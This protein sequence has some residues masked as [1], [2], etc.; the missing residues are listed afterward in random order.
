MPFIKTLKAYGKSA[1]IMVEAKAKD[2]A[3]LK[4]VEEL[5]KVRGFKRITG[6]GIEL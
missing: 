6:G 2:K 5:S 4:L 1:D 3:S